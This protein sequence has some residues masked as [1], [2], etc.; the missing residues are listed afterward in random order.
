MLHVFVN[1]SL[2]NPAG[3]PGKG[4]VS[5][6]SVPLRRVIVNKAGSLPVDAGR[7]RKL[8]IIG[9]RKRWVTEPESIADGRRNV[10]TPIVT[11]SPAGGKLPTTLVSSPCRRESCPR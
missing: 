3:R 10:D 4:F 5:S 8:E 11:A 1:P 9:R 7:G 2:G 6:R